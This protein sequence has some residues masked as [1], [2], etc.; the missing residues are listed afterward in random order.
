MLT[1]KS[2]WFVVLSFERGRTNACVDRSCEASH[3]SRMP[4]TSAASLN[5]LD[6]ASSLGGN[7]VILHPRA[8]QTDWT[9]HERMRI[10]RFPEIDFMQGKA[11][12][13]AI[14]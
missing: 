14:N 11:N 8:M 1:L 6:R 9:T 13:P 12:T 4:D 7:S 10:N 2:V 3:P 5:R